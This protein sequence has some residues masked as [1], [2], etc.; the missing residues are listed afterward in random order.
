MKK[1][2]G[3]VVT[4]VVVVVVV[5]LLAMCSVKIPAGMLVSSIHLTEELKVK[6]FHR[7]YILCRQQQK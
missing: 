6:F 3:G 1:A 7:D 5:V 2:V 4:A